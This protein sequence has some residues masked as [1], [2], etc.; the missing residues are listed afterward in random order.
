MWLLEGPR[1]SKNFLR[2][3]SVAIYYGPLINYAVIRPLATAMLSRRASAENMGCYDSNKLFG[4]SRTKRVEDRE[5]APVS[6][7][8]QASDN[9]NTK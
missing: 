9:V 4:C 6:P 5:D 3:L 8:S 1:A 2:S 7:T